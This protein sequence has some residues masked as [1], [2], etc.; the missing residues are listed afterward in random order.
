MH[1]ENKGLICRGLMSGVIRHFRKLSCGNTF[2]AHSRKFMSVKLQLFCELLSR[3]KF[4]TLRKKC[5]YSELFRSAFSRIWTE[6]GEIR[7]IQDQK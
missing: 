1:N 6:Y 3:R 4:P 2:L 5:P 7:S